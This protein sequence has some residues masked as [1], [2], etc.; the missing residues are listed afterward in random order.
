MSHTHDLDITIDQISKIEG[1]AEISVSVRNGE[2]QD[3]ELKINENKRFYTQAVRNKNYVGVPQLVSR[4]CGTCSVA[5]LNCSIM[6]LENGL[7][8]ELSAQDKLLRELS[9]HGLMIREVR[10]AAGAA[11]AADQLRHADIVLVAHG[12]G[13]ETLVLVDLEL[14]ILHLAVSDGD[15]YLGVAL[16][17]GYLV[18]G[19]VEVMGVR[20]W[21]RLPRIR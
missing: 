4:I 11:D 2:V 9:M 20:H 19:D 17:L 1:H 14:D 6:A 16:D 7:G 13:V 21:V 12:L 3:V 5:H 10:D 18:D 8:L 15:R